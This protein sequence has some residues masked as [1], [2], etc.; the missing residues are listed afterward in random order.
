MLALA[1]FASERPWLADAVAGAA[2]DLLD[3]YD[4]QRRHAANAFLQA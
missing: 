3:L 4:R 1:V 2:N